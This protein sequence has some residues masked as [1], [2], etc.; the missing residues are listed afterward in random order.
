MTPLQWL[1][2]KNQMVDCRQ[3]GCDQHYTSW[4]CLWIRQHLFTDDSKKGVESCEKISNDK[5]LFRIT[6]SKDN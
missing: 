2:D 6:K 5:M 3:D 1:K 4:I